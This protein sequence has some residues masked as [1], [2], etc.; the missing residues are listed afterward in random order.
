ML[1]LILFPCDGVSFVTFIFSSLPTFQVIQ[2]MLNN[3]KGKWIDDII[4]VSWKRDAKPGSVTEKGL[5][6]RG[7]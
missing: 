1:S 6:N 5:F 7:W 4:K 3:F 2:I